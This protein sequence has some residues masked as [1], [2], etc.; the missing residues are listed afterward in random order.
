MVLEVIVCIALMTGII[1]ADSSWSITLT[2]P[3]GEITV[4]PA[5]LQSII[6]KKGVATQIN[7]QSSLGAP[8]WRVT[9]LADK[10]K[11]LGPGDIVHITGETNLDIPYPEIAKNDKYLIIDEKSG[12]DLVIRSDLSGEGV[13][14]ITSIGISTTDEWILHVRSDGVDIEIPKEKW[15]ELILHHSTEKVTNAG[16]FRG[17]TLPDLFASQNIVPVIDTTVKITGQD[18]Y[19]TEIP[20][21]TI[22]GTK[23]YLIADQLDGSDLPKYIVGLF[24]PDLPTPAWPLMHISPDFPGN[25]S[26]GNINAIDILS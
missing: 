18:G 19:S 16:T 23:D 6:E 1:I 20:W 9:A 26:V 22:A 2:G 12:P 13:K 10:G 21:E 5:D 14:K 4:S 11:T 17:I 7:G 24:A 15:K 8:L 25:D 3:D